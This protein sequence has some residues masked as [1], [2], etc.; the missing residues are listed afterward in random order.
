MVPRHDDAGSK[1]V[2]ERISSHGIILHTFDAA[3]NRSQAGGTSVV[4][5]GTSA[6]GWTGCN[7]CNGFIGTTERDAA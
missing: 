5:G 1:L 7:G 4:T 6:S 3:R 2:A